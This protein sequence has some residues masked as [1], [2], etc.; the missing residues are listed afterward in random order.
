MKTHY[1]PL[2]AI[3]PN[4]VTLLLGENTGLNVHASID[5]AIELLDQN[6][7]GSVLYLNTVQTPRSM[8]DSAR[9]HGLAPDGNGVCFVGGKFGKV[10]YI[11][12]IT[13]GNLHKSREKIEYMLSEG[14][15]QYVMINSWEFASKNSRYREESVFLLKE[16]TS[17][18]RS[19]FEPVS[20]IVYA[21]EQSRETRAQ[22]IQRGGFG[23]LAGVVAKVEIITIEN[24]FETEEEMSDREEMQRGYES[25][26]GE[27]KESM[28][29]SRL[30]MEGEKKKSEVVES[31][32]VP[33]KSESRGPKV[34]DAEFSEISEEATSDME[35][36][37]APVFVPAS[38]V[39]RRRRSK[40]PAQILRE[41]IHLNDY[42]PDKPA[43]PGTS[44]IRPSA[45]TPTRPSSVHNDLVKK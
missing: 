22:K 18:M 1:K 3:A 32:D 29:D 16:L 41:P 36:H 10:I 26:E 15:I 30:S 38:K 13:R 25:M 19:D 23:K 5:H 39:G 27:H 24:E 20:A 11:M 6:I 45:N 42:S 4:N 9:S 37:M 7:P 28:V 34:E 17:G 21:E 8:Y 35:V 31:A 43:S 2:P 12:N 44:S 33:K 14:R 40:Q